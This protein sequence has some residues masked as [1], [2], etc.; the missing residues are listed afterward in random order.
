MQFALAVCLIV[1]Q[2]PVPPAEPT[3]PPSDATPPPTTDPPAT[4]PAEV[5][6]PKNQTMCATGCVPLGEPCRSTTELAPVAPP[7]ATRDAGE[8][9]EIQE[10]SR[11]RRARQTAEGAEWEPLV[12]W[13][14]RKMRVGV[15]LGIPAA[16][17]LAPPLFFAAI[18][19]FQQAPTRLKAAGAVF[20]VTGGVLLLLALILPSTMPRRRVELASDGVAFRF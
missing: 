3:S 2:A 19:G 9:G 10:F 8:D 4:A 16:G 5:T 13:Q 20:G 6:C 1:A 15:A 17:L 7:P 11:G 18:G 12:E 14:V